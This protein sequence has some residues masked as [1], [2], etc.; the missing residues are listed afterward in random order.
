MLQNSPWE[1][2]SEVVLLNPVVARRQLLPGMDSIR[3]LWELY[4]GLSVL[5][6]FVLFVVCGVIVM[7]YLYEMMGHH[8]SFHQLWVWERA[9]SLG[10]P[11]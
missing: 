2:V 11:M 1:V 8:Q 9:I 10:P 5:V 3:L 7:H 6:L 4:L